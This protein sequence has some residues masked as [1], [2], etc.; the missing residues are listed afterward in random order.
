MDR[1]TGTSFDLPTA[2]ISHRAASDAWIVPVCD[3]AICVIVFDHATFISPVGDYSDDD[4]I[5]DA[6][7]RSADYLKWLERQMEYENDRLMHGENG[8]GF[9]NAKGGKA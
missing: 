4:M 1:G 3:D 5:A 7:Y 8:D 9:V 2:G 6:L